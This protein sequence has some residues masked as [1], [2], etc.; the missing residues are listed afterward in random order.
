VLHFES[1]LITWE[2]RT[3]RNSFNSM[4]LI[5]SSLLTVYCIGEIQ[6]WI[7]GIS[8]IS[9]SGLTLRDTEEGKIKGMH[10]Q[11]FFGGECV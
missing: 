11:T 1:G 4:A 7:D 3:V 10:F 2:Q 6:L 9:V 8:A 5:H